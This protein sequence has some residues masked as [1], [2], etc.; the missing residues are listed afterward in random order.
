[1]HLLWLIINTP[2]NLETLCRNDQDTHAADTQQTL[3]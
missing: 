3:Q 1:M 2:R